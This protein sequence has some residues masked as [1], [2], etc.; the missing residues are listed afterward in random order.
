[1]AKTAGTNAGEKKYVADA[2]MNEHQRRG[3]TRNVMAQIARGIALRT[4]NSVKHYCHFEGPERANRQIFP[5][6]NK[7]FRRLS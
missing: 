4:R 2:L 5:A 3:K 7:N 6:I 1:M